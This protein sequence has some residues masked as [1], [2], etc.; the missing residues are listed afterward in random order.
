MR[1][2][3][4]VK[5]S[6]LVT[7]SLMLFLAALPAL[8]GLVAATQYCANAFQ[9]HPILG[10]AVV[11]HGTPL[12]A[13]WAWIGWHRRFPRRAPRTFAAAEA[14]TFG[15]GLLSLLI[16]LAAVT[17]VRQKGPSTAHGS[18]RWATTDDLRAAGLL[19]G[20]GVVLCQ[21][22]DA[23]LRSEPDGQGGRRW[24]QSRPGALIRHGGPE[25]VLVF[26]PARSGKGIGTVVPTLLSW[27][28][29]VVVYDI[30]KELWQLTAGWRRSF[31]QCWR[32]E[33][34]GVGGV[35]HP[36][37]PSRRAGQDAARRVGLPERSR[38]EC[39]SAPGFA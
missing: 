14:I 2:D 30:K 22:A 9:Y 38:R 36:A 5:Q 16:V 27:N 13:P 31:S 28:A 12:Y 8:G 35:S 17:R 20:A 15:G 24:R 6:I 39:C 10:R 26:A 3:K 32:F 1:A 29:S 34:T 19:D 25:H 37:C 7:A 23:R 33:P 4:T 11:I 21:T 18:A